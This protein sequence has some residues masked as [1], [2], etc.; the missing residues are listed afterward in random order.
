MNRTA[1]R[2]SQS[3]A[4]TETVAQTERT[5]RT[6]QHP[7]RNSQRSN[8]QAASTLR[9]P[10]HASKTSVSR[11][12][13]STVPRSASATSS[14][15]RATTSPAPGVA[16]LP[17]VSEEPAY[18]A[19]QP[20]KAPGQP[21]DPAPSL[22]PAPEAQS[23]SQQQTQAA[24]RLTNQPALPTNAQVSNET[25]VQPDSNTPAVANKAEPAKQPE[26]GDVNSNDKPKVFDWY[27][28]DPNRPR[29]VYDQPQYSSSSY[30][31]PQYSS[32]S[33]QQPQYSYSSYQQPQYSSSSYQN[34]Q[35]SSYPQYSSYQTQYRY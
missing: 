34:S 35:Y 5:S 28:Y 12:A 29:Y 31:Q 10:S 20:I 30:Q 21:D 26:S 22:T 3:I 8:N 7:S 14:L 24:S 17:P 32:S 25:A 23:V 16:V 13:P 9:A 19:F 11:L 2:A 4:P 18:A 1:T 6:S 15:I 33:Y 27:V